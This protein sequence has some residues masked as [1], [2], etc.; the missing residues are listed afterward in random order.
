MVK[1]SAL[2]VQDPKSAAAEFV[3]KK[4]PVADYDA[5][6]RSYRVCTTTCIDQFGLSV[7]CY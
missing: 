6:L 2:S 5:T 4:Q 1:M 7:K 3:E